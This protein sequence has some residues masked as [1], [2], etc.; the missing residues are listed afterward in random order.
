MVKKI[1]ITLLI[2][3][4]LLA[5][6]YTLAEPDFISEI[7]GKKEALKKNLYD[8]K[9]RE[10]VEL[11]NYKGIVLP[12]S[13][14]TYS[15]LVNPTYTLPNDIARFDKDGK[16]NGVLYP[17]GYTFNPVDYLKVLPPPIVVYNACKPQE[18][19]LAK[20]IASSFKNNVMMVD[21][22]CEVG[23]MPKENFKVFVL[24]KEMAEKF[25]LKNTLSVIRVDKQLRGIKVDVYK[26]TK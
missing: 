9:E 6:T 10:L 1:A 26:T 7:Y 24:T 15:Y 13:K 16:Q 3:N 25:K 23:K 8:Q 20:S 14:K 4:S 21:S 22:G 2:T 5:Q 11:Y 18:V 12:S 19:L 17:K